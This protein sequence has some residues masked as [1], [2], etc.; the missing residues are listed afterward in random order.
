MHTQN[1]NNI[2]L[3]AAASSMLLTHVEAQSAPTGGRRPLTQTQTTTPERTLNHVDTRATLVRRPPFANTRQSRRSVTNTNI[4]TFAAT[5]SWKRINVLLVWQKK[6]ARTTH[7]N[8]DQLPNRRNLAQVNCIRS[9]KETRREP[10]RQTI[11]R[12]T[13]NCRTDD[14]TKPHARVTRYETRKHELGG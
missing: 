2:T 4:P 9:H 3:N 13:A 5:H 8:H 14:A 7:T 11:Q 12:P 6:T 1:L 10:K